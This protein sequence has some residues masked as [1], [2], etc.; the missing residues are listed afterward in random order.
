[1]TLHL[2]FRVL[3]S[4]VNGQAAPSCRDTVSPTSDPAAY[5]SFPEGLALS[6]LPCGFKK[7]LSVP[8]FLLWE[9][10]AFLLIKKEYVSIQ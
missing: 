6:V 2:V 3:S 1:M 9:K 5:G 4:E 10:F 7:K 8:N